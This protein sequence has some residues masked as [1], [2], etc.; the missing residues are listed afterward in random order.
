MLQMNTGKI[1]SGSPCLGSW[2][3][4]GLGTASENLPGFAVMLALGAAALAGTSFP[5]NREQTARALGFDRPTANS[6]DAVSDRDFVMEANEAV[7]YGIIDEVISSRA[8]VDR[9]GPI[10]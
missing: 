2:V 1:L 8:I 10:R 3:N 5:I 7:A 6:L 9:S 4:Y